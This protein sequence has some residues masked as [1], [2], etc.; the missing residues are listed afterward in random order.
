MY[1]SGVKPQESGVLTHSWKSQPQTHL[2]KISCCSKQ[3]HGSK[4]WQGRCMFFKTEGLGDCWGDCGFSRNGIDWNGLFSERKKGKHSQAPPCQPNTQS[5]EGRIDS[6]AIQRRWFPP[7]G[8]QPGPR[9]PSPSPLSSNHLGNTSEPLLES[10]YLP[11]LW[12]WDWSHMEG[13]CREC[14]VIILCLWFPEEDGRVEDG[15][16]QAPNLFPGVKFKRDMLR[17]KSLKMWVR[18]NKLQVD[19]YWCLYRFFKSVTFFPHVLAHPCQSLQNSENCLLS[20]ILIKF[21]KS[22]FLRIHL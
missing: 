21:R 16:D 6:S 17:A 12:G 3:I 7:R 9:L 4:G 18:C 2:H 20:Y 1:L 19:L 11:H 8:R 15:I 10:V 5:S 14:A 13:T 22:D